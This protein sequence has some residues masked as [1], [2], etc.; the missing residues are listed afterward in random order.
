MLEPIYLPQIV[1]NSDELAERGG[2]YKRASIRSRMAI[3]W[4]W[5]RIM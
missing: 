1:G 4:I 3:P 2:P 5:I